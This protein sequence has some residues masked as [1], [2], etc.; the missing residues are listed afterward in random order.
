MKIAGYIV[1][2]KNVL[3]YKRGGLFQKKKEFVEWVRF[4]NKIYRTEEI[5]RQAYKN[6]P[7]GGGDSGYNMAGRI[8]PVYRNEDEQPV[9]IKKQKS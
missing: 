4:S 3:H 6:C 8:I 1:E 9:L 5:A 2:Q 7:Y